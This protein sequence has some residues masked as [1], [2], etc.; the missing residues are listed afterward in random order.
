M[1]FPALI[2][3]YTIKTTIKINKS[4]FKTYCKPCIQ[5]LGEEKGKKNVFPNKT[6]RI[7]N[8]FKKCPH[9]LSQANEDEKNEIFDLEKEDK[10]NQADSKKRKCK[11]FII[12]YYKYFFLKLIYNNNF[13]I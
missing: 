12:L 1:P 6:D 3:K 9:F 11:Y 2:A 13:L 7:I 5:V 10:N 8:H 4:N